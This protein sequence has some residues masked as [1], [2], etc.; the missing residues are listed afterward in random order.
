M[1]VLVRDE[2]L[3]AVGRVSPCRPRRRRS[4]IAQLGGGGI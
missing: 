2:R 1:E 3:S 4:I